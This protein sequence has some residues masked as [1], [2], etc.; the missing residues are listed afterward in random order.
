MDAIRQSLK[1]IETTTESSITSMVFGDLHLEHIKAWREDQLRPLGFATEYPLWHVSYDNLMSDL[2]AS[3]VDFVISASSTEEAKVG[4]SFDQAFF[5]K[6]EAN[7]E[8][9]SFGEKGEFH[10]LAQVWT[11]NRATALGINTDS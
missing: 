10:S 11:S 2:L 3:H 1:L 4:Q 6:L 9:D 5:Q 7:K 8:I